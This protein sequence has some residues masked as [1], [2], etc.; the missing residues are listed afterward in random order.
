MMEE[1]EYMQEAV[2]K[3]ELPEELFNNFYQN[4]QQKIVED[5]MAG[6]VKTTGINQITQLKHQRLGITPAPQYSV[7]SHS[8]NLLTRSN[9]IPEPNY[10]VRA[11]DTDETHL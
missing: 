10:D 8:Q 3:E 5:I 11:M 6:N 2:N 4:N 7:H 1:S 9:Y